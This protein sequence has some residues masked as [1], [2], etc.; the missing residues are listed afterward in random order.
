MLP[1]DAAAQDVSVDIRFVW[2]D[3]EFVEKSGFEESR[4]TSGSYNKE[5]S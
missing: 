2:F 3:P 4:R 1:M 5:R